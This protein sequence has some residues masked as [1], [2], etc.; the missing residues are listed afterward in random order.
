MLVVSS[1]IYL[2]MGQTGI[3]VARSREERGEF[4]RHLL[5]DI[6][7]LA[8]MVEHDLF[9][10]DISRIGAEQEFCLL[11]RNWRPAINSEV[12]LKAL[13]DPHFTTE[14]ARYNLEIN[15]DPLELK[16]GCF[17]EMHKNLDALLKKASTQAEKEDTHV[18]LT[19][20]LPT[21]SKNELDISY[22]TPL[23]RYYALNEA[24]KQQRRGDFL[25][26][27]D[28]V[29][30]LSIMHDSVLFEAC[31]TSFQL[32]LQIS[33]SDFISS[34]NWAQA[35]AAPVLGISTNSP[36]LLGRELWD[37]TRIALFQQSIDTRLSSYNLKEQE[38]RVSFG[39]QWEAGS[40]VDIFQHDITRH[41]VI[42]A[43]TI[44]HDSLDAL[45]RNEIPQLQ[46]L[47]I[48]NGTVYRWNRPCYGAHQG[49]AHLRIENRYLPSGPTTLDEMANFALWVGLMTGRPAIYDDMASRMDF[50]DAKANFF[51]TAK[52][53]MQSVLHWGDEPRFLRELLEKELLPIAYSGLCKAGISNDEAHKY[54]G[55]IENRL[56]GKNGS[57][58]TLAGYRHARKTLKKDDALLLITKS[59]YQNQQTDMAVHEW[60]SVNSDLEAHESAYL[61][62]HVMSTRLFTV[63][64]NDLAMLATT[65]MRWNNVHHVP[66]EDENGH[67]CGLLTW[68]H[69]IRNQKQE[70][71]PELLVEDIMEKE[72]IFVTP[73]SGI[74]ESIQIMKKHEIGCL[75]VVSNNE[76]I[77]IVT[78]QDVLEFDE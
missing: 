55:V 78:I 69:M 20:I 6:R 41:K 39:F 1:L 57:E 52:T 7:A 65:L 2:V 12:I 14:L 29:D 32:H 70:E 15:L 72:V 8:F 42:L 45:E 17:I 22:M 73:S 11:N 71:D 59:M 24:V 62:E 18:F 9:E 21:I 68:T 26:T 43:T 54:L 66:V 23:P 61:I 47:R 27:L 35:I 60:P 64:D 46:A 58:W 3:H 25:V 38:P 30:E 44:E 19:G 49:K 13:N 34:Y 5:H 77:G 74:K 67:L 28:G 48:H 31:N 53:G 51:K 37:E 16:S 75:P 40:I 76:L 4:I 33:S 50:R 10:R 56:K 36:L 63:M